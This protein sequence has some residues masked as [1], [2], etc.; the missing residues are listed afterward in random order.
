[1]TLFADEF[2]K[3]FSELLAKSG[4]SCYKIAQFANLDQ[5][6]LSRLKDGQKVN[7]STE[8][9]VK[10]CIALAQFSE[11]LDIFDFEKLLN[12]N[13]R[14]LFPKQRSNSG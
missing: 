9:V 13:G 11:R 3:I 2:A 5:A 7:P 8:T 4:V 12:A 6:Y 10:I 1:M 14:S